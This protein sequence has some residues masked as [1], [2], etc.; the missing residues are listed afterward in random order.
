MGDAP[1]GFV[2]AGDLLVPAHA[3]SRPAGAS[4]YLPDGTMISV[5][6]PPVPA[7]LRFL[8][9]WNHRA[10]PYVAW[11]T[12]SGSVDDVDVDGERYLESLKRRLC[13]MCGLNLGYWIAWT[14]HA[15]TAGDARKIRTMIEPAMHRPCA[16]YY[17]DAYHPERQWLYVA[18]TYAQRDTSSPTRPVVAYA[19][20]AREIEAI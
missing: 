3:A 15:D 20:P 19:A 8:E 7:G 10:V 12:P 6:S 18:R 16:R 11:R 17:R 1:A 4:L 2:D 5:D 14:I 13:G 9:E